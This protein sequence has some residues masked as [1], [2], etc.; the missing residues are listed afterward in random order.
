[1]SKTKVMTINDIKNKK[2]EE[3]IVLS[4]D[5]DTKIS[6]IEYIELLEHLNNLN[7][8]IEKQADQQEIQ[9]EEYELLLTEYKNTL[10]LVNKYKK[11]YE[12]K[13]SLQKVQEEYQDELLKNKLEAEEIAKSRK[14]NKYSKLSKEEVSK[15]ALEKHLVRMKNI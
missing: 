9:N 12:D 14:L 1:M 2:K 13:V 4:N 7:D 11:H 3:V 10:A 8:V 15:L 5:K 6:Q